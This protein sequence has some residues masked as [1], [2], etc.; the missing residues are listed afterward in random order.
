M[1]VQ[2]GHGIQQL[3]QELIGVLLGEIFW[4]CGYPLAKCLAVDI[5]HQYAV[6]CQR[7]IA[8]E[9]GVLQPIARLKLLTKSFL[10]ADVSCKLRLQPFQEVQLAIELH[11]KAVTGGSMRIYLFD[12]LER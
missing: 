9:V 2:T 11:P 7:D 5:L 12:A 8:H 3:V 1:A 10:I 4:M 6:I